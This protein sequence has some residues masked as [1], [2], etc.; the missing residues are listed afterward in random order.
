MLAGLL[1]YLLNT[2]NLSVRMLNRKAARLELSLLRSRCTCAS[3][4]QL[5]GA[6]LFAPKTVRF[7][8]RRT[9]PPRRRFMAIR[10]RRRRA[11]P[12]LVPGA[13]ACGP[14]MRTSC[15]I[16]DH[17]GEILRSERPMYVNDGLMLA[18]ARNHR[19]R[20]PLPKR[21]HGYWHL[22]V[23]GVVWDIGDRDGGVYDT[24]VSSGCGGCEWSGWTD[25]V[26]GCGCCAVVQHLQPIVLR[27]VSNERAPL[28]RAERPGARSRHKGCPSHIAPAPVPGESL[29]AGRQRG[30]AGS[31][32]AP[33]P[34]TDARSLAESAG[35]IDTHRFGFV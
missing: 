34:S 32:T 33:D 12:G 26:D 18:S 8:W 24:T 30:H 13:D 21:L 4:R 9:L 23:A 10:Q 17:G 16:T 29:A 1:H 2:H 19:R 35:R 14:L 5:L 31:A 15:A 3:I 11:A 20:R 27:A 22:L 25:G 6:C 7:I 28:T